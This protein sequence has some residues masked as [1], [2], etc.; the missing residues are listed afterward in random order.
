MGLKNFAPCQEKGKVPR[1]SSMPVLSLSQD[2]TERRGETTDRMKAERFKKKVVE[3]FPS[4][5]DG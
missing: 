3:R 5:Q 4:L 2:P 1:I